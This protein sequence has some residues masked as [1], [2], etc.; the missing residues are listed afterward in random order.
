MFLQPQSNFLLPLFLSLLFPSALA[1][2]LPAEETKGSDGIAGGVD[3]TGD[4]STGA[5]GNSKGSV[6]LS[7]QAQVAIIVVVVIVAV[8]GITSGILFYLAKKRQWAVRAT[9]RRSTRKIAESIKS[10]IALRTPGGGLL[11]PRFPRTPTHPSAKKG[12]PDGYNAKNSRGRSESRREKKIPEPKFK[13]VK[14]EMPPPGRRKRDEEGGEKQVKEEKVEEKRGEE[15][16]S[17][18]SIWTKFSSFSRKG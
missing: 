18:G 6:N 7:N 4:G 13:T 16:D 10:P 2:P 1:A 12:S 5:S 14:L 8:F 9:I 17:T 15:K 3:E 11:S